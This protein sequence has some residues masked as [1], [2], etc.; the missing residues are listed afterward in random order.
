MLAVFLFTIVI[1][2][3]AVGI[4]VPISLGT[5]LFITDI[6]P[7]KLRS[8]LVATID[9]MAAVP[10]V[11]YGLWGLRILQP[12]VVPI[13]RWINTWFGWI[14]IFRVEGA[15][16]ESPFL[17][18]SVYS[19]S[20]FMAGLVV[21]LMVIPIQTSVMRQVFSQVPPGEREGAYAL[22]STRWGMITTVAIPFGKSGIIG[23]TMLG[24]GRALGETIAVVLIVSPRFDFHMHILEL[25]SNSISAHI[26][27]RY[28]EASELEL[29]ALFAAGLVLF[30]LTLVVNFTASYFVTRSR[31]GAGSEA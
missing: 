29:S 28:A 17:N 15:D 3:I 22:G 26:A 5:A 18:A 13:S 16:P 19:A 10:S 14:P 9:L 4:S 25:G 1:A 7:P 24:L 27:L 23:G 21:S 6:A 30:M 11:V 31:S 8:T 12:H 2:V 20:S